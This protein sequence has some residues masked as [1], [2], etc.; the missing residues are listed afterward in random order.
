MNKNKVIVI[1]AVAVLLLGAAFL[2]HHRFFRVDEKFFQLDYQRLQTAPGNVMIFRDTHFPESRR[3]GCFT[4]W[5]Q[6]KPG[7]EQ[8]V[9]YLGRNVGLDQIMP[10]AYQ[11][12]PS[13]VVMPPIAP[14][15]HFDFLIT[16]KAKAAE[17]LQAAVKK[18][19]G[20][21]AEWK[22]RETDVYLLKVK[23]PNSPGLRASTNQS[24]GINFK[25]GRLVFTHM[26]VSQLSSFVENG[27]K[28]PVQDQ[29]GLT[30]YYDYSVAWNW[31]T[32]NSVDEV[33]LKKSL[34]ELGLGLEDGS[35]MMRML[36]VQKAK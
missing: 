15:N 22:E 2:I 11:C 32:Q 20:Y 34:A 25:N 10:L 33:A 24:G 26:Q 18:K 19:T 27:L 4:A 7:E 36:V 30:G 21:V 28:K 14:T 13:R 12:Q 8:S 3:S 5:M 31:R 6:S 1:S 17:L 35:D 16:R 9:R 29:T 23:I